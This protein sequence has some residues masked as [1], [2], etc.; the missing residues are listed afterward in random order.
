MALPMADPAAPASPEAPVPDASVHSPIAARNA[1]CF[2]LFRIFFNCRFY[3]PVFTILFL[4]FGLSLEQFAALNA[5][6]AVTIVVL[7]VPSGALADQLGRRRLVVASAV[8]MVLE[9]V[10][11]VLM[12]RQAGDLTFWVFALNR[13]LSGA[14]EACASGADEALTYDSLPPDGREAAWQR[15]Q[16]RLLRWSSLVFLVVTVVGAITYDATRMTALARGLGLDVTLD[17]EV[18]MRF[19]LIL[20]LGMAVAALVTARRF[21]PSPGEPV[22]VSLD[23]STL[24]TA[25]RGVAATGRWILRTPVVLVLL[26]TGLLGDSFLR[27]FYS[28]ASQFYRALRIPAEFYGWIGAAGSLLGFATAGLLQ[29]L[30]HTLT[31]S[32]AYRLVAAL[33]FAGLLGLAHPVAWWG[34]WAVV[35]FWLGM[36][37]LHF[38]LTHHLN[39]AVPAE[40]RATAL[41]FRGLSMNLAYGVVMQLFGLQT[42]WLAGRLG[43]G[44]GETAV[45]SA[46]AVWWPWAFAV[47]QASLFGWV[48]LRYRR[49][50]TG[51]MADG[52]ASSPPALERT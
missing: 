37:A 9:M 38:F 8:L 51:L 33:V 48:A 10:C 15:I 52:N 36:R 3:Y 46:A 12:P 49:S 45:F 7:E 47:S 17:P 34:L 27:L 42:A 43:P 40:S 11:L 26:L 29:H 28:V 35:P 41:S 44:T 24:A 25:F 6:W 22:R 18:T 21:L 4:D 1:L 50:L 5:L 31:P 20:C 23:W 32:A 2:V 16:V 13:V 30:V 19:P 14:A 39:Q